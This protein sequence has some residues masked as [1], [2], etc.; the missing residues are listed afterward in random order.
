MKLFLLFASDRSPIE[1]LSALG[2]TISRISYDSPDIYCPTA[3]TCFNTLDLPEY[4]GLEVLRHKLV[5]AIENSE[6]FGFV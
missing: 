3:H 6:G 1:G 5:M 4:S 2:F